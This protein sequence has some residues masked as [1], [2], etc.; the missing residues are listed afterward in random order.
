MAWPLTMTPVSPT[1]R[2]SLSYDLV[3]VFEILCLHYLFP[4]AQS[5]IEEDVWVAAKTKK[6]QDDLEKLFSVLDTS[7]KR[8]GRVL[9]RDM[10]RVINIIENIGVCPASQ[11]L[12]L[13]KCCGDV[14]VDVERSKRTEL[15]E[16]CFSLI[17]RIPSSKLDISHYN[18]LLKVIPPNT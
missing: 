17:S 14:L 13:V 3:S 2:L 9:E 10:A 15:V 11:A 1:M 6:S 5:L 8:Q 4:Q 12:L 18:A 16:R 7:F